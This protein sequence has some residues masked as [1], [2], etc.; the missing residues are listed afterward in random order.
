MSRSAGQNTEELLNRVDSDSAT[1]SNATIHDGSSA[2]DVT[3]NLA[4][5]DRPDEVRVIVQNATGAYS[6]DVAFENTTVSLAS[7]TTSDT[8]ATQAV[9]SNTTVDVTISDDSAASNTVDYDILLI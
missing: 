4:V 5:P 9:A 2:T 1:D 6:V 7:S 8:E 3:E